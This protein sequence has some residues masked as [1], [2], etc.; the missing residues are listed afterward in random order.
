M[1]FKNKFSKQEESHAQK[2]EH[3]QEDHL[4]LRRQRKLRKIW[5]LNLLKALSKG[6]IEKP[7]N[8]PMASKTQETTPDL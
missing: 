7:K 4:P 2:I 8:V 6:V 5:S 3:S 1:R